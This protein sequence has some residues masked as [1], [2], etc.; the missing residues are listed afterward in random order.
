[1]AW[2][3]G[4]DGRGEVGFADA[5]VC[6]GGAFGASALSLSC[7]ERTSNFVLLSR[8]RIFPRPGHLNSSRSATQ[9][10]GDGREGVGG[11]QLLPGAGRALLQWARRR[12]SAFSIKA[13]L[14]VNLGMLAF[15]TK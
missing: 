11:V 7:L 10:V 5:Q 4:V 8:A 1:M 13:C 3:R 2:G 9:P 12:L 15:S 6:A 14:F